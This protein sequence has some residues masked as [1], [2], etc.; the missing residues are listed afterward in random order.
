MNRKRILIDIETLKT[1]T[2]Y[3]HWIPL[4]QGLHRD[5]FSSHFP[6]WE[7]NDFV[8]KL[9][10]MKILSTKPNNEESQTKLWQGLYI[11]SEIEAIEFNPKIQGVEINVRLRA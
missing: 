10:R 9:L 11:S 1:I 5:Y 6:G 7:W 4:T 2:N 8:P 3:A